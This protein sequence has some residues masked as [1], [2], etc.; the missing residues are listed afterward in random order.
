MA[1][2]TASPQQH[3]LPLGFVRGEPLLDK[4]EDLYIPPDA[5]ELILESFSGPMDLLLY[6]IRRQKLDI[7]DLPILPITRQYMEYVEMMKELK[8]EL[9]ADYLVMA[10]MLAEIKSR[11]LLPRPPAEDEEE[12]D[13]RA[14]LVRRLQEYEAIRTGAGYLDEMPQTE[15]DL[16]VVQAETDAKDL[17]K[18]HLP[19]IALAELAVAF[20][21]AMA[22]AELQNHHQIHREKL[23]T[24]E[25]MSRILDLLQTKQRLRFAD[26]FEPSEGKQGV[27]V[28]FLAILELSKEALVDVVQVDA[29]SEIHITTREQVYAESTD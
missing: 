24:R 6:L 29:F 13:P 16:F 28:S 14:E 12:T 22:Q 17:V 7:V 21:R 26:L 5:L 8:L 11:M 1:G 2:S 10:A 20:S 18:Q 19:D 25:R 15:R 3:S 4:P 9:A 27:V 23:S